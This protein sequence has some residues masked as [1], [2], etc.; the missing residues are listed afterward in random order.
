MIKKYSNSISIVLMILITGVTQVLTLLKS[1]LVANYF[2]ASSEMD[3]YNF[4]NSIVSFIF[5]FV[6]AAISTVIIPN[7]VNN[8]NRK[9]VDSFITMLYGALVIIIVLVILLRFQIVGVFSNREELFVNIACN[10]LIVLLL[11]NYLLSITNITASY[12]QCVGKYN[13]PKII[14]LISQLCVI[15]VL[16]VCPEITIYKYTIIIACGVLINFVI[17]IIIAVKVGWRYTPSFK[18]RDTET[19]R[20]VKLFAPIVLS[21]G[22]YQLSLMIDSV[23]ASRLDAGMLTVLSYASQ[24]T[25]MISNLLIGNLLIYCYPKIVK[26]INDANSKTIFWE[27]ASF[28]HLVVCL[29]VA[30]FAT[31]GYDGIALL[32]EHGKFDSM[33]TRG[34]FVGTL[35]YLCGQQTNIVRD[36]IYRYFY[37]SGDTKTAASNSI[38]VSIVNIISSIIFVQFLGVYGIILGT[39]FASFVSL[40]RILYQFGRKLGF[41]VKIKSIVLPLVVNIMIACATIAIVM[42]TQR[43]IVVDLIVERIALYGIE[44]VIVFAFFTLVSQ[45]RRIKRIIQGL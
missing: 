43:L 1:S 14:N 37:A 33:A 11:S 32:F 17:D 24:I 5:G 7:Y 40:F 10:V 29:V 15:I 16:L 45:K 44:T 34:V 30:G 12:Y 27:Q 20:M 31:V 4:A 35:I 8:N 41:G 25:G 23:F 38:L 36:L 28:F 39:V 2:G 26:R 42:I 18:F 9:Q 19:K 21:S 22:V 13:T 3:A 6:A